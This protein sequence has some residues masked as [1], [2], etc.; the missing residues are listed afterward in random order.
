[1]IYRQLMKEL[2]KWSEK[3]NRKPLVLRGARQVGKT[4]LVDEF[5]KRYDVYIK[6]NLEQSADAFIFSKSDNVKEIYQ[7][8]CVQKKIVV[9]PARRTLLF[10]DEIQ[11]EPKAVGLLRYFYEELPWL[12][13]IAAG[14]RLQTLIKQRVSFPVGR[15]EY[16]SLR[17]CSFLEY[18]GAMGEDVMA[19]MI[20]NVDVSAI[21]HDVLLSHFNRYTLVGGM[22]EALVDYAQNGDVVRLSP[23]YRSLLDGYNE[24]VEKYARNDS[25][26]RVMRHLL[27]HGWAEAG[28]T[29]TFNRFGGSDYSSKEVHEALEV[30]QKAF[31]L[32]LDY[33]VTAVKAPAVPAQTRQ[34]KLVWVDSG[35]MNFSVDIQSEYL[36]NDSLLDV[37]KGHAAEQIVAQ[38]LR[39][40]LDR[41][42]RNELYYWVRDK[43]GSNAE[44]DFVWQYQSVIIPIEVKSGT[45]AHLR[46]IHS[47]M[48]QP[49]A[50]DV[51]V[52]IWPG[53]FAIDE[54]V[55]PTGHP[56]R[57]INLPF[58]YVGVLDKVL[59]KYVK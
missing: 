30:M 9:N 21:Y 59:E 2:Q 47:F 17:P 54:L 25:Q 1:M 45:N 24:D 43:K 40:V 39:V 42:Y 15:V 48:S 4:T 44:I 20:S 52:R 18:L 32:S 28:Q 11:N 19:Q 49:G 50:P 31:L 36:Q 46:S 38:E 29:I 6:L 14:S 37:W 51:A 13:I 34:P 53:N 35:I 56:F 7:Y 57:L 23:I 5:S 27:T 3:N 41:N 8:L 22:P 26:A 55:S 58:Y 10:I 12:H 16:L 33:P